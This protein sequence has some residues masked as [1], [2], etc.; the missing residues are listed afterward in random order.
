MDRAE[1][2]KEM[3]WAISHHQMNNRDLFDE[4][5][6]RIYDSLTVPAGMAYEN[7]APGDLLIKGADGMVRRLEATATQPSDTPPDHATSKEATATK[8]V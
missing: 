4:S 8:P 7:I 3:D 1:F 2:I 6:G 5:M